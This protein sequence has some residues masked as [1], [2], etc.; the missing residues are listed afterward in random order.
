MIILFCRN[1]PFLYTS[2]YVNNRFQI[3]YFKH[4]S[5]FLTESNIGRNIYYSNRLL[6]RVVM[7]FLCFLFLFDCVS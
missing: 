4:V 5:S 2:E 1:I 7:Y 3:W 6:K